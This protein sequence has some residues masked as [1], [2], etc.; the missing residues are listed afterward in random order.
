VTAPSGAGAALALP[1]PPLGAILLRSRAEALAAFQRLGW[2][3]WARPID[4]DAER[5]RI[6]NIDLTEPEVAWLG[7]E[8]EVA[9]AAHVETDRGGRVTLVEVTGAG[10]V[11]PGHVAAAFL[12]VSG[13]PIVSGAAEAR[14]WV[15]GP[16][17]GGAATIGGEPVRLWMCQERAYGERLWAV[18]SVVRHGGG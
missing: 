16:E 6:L 18:A 13:K 11:E 15:W 8:G 3:P 14:Q 2:R 4:L 10:P 17:A 9:A 12:G 5:R 7:A 1:L